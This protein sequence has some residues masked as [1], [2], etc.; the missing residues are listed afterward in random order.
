MVAAKVITKG[1]EIVSE[2]WIDGVGIAEYKTKRVE[3]LV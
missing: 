1:N 2:R 3:A